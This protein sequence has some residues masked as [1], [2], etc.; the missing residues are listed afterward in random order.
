MI[1]NGVGYM[2]RVKGEYHGGGATV[3]N[4]RI[5]N[6]RRVLMAA[7]DACSKTVGIGKN[8]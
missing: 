5:E 6:L 2:M 4:M 8:I 1:G 7:G 3:G